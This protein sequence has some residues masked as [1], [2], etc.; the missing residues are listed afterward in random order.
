MIFITGASGFIGKALTR[1]LIDDNQSLIILTRDSSA[2]EAIG[3][4]IIVEGDLSD[5]DIIES[6]IEQYSIDTMIHL[7]W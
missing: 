2:Y 3:D 7:A 1:R 4:E 5:I 6:Q